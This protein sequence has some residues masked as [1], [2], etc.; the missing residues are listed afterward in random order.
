MSIIL[1]LYILVGNKKPQQDAVVAII[2]DYT[3]VMYKQA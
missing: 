1:I 2:L 3:N